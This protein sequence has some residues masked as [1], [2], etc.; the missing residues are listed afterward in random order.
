MDV[1]QMVEYIPSKIKLWVQTK[2][3][4][5]RRVYPKTAENS[6]QK[7]TADKLIVPTGGSSGMGEKLGNGCGALIELQSS[8]RVCHLTVLWGCFIWQS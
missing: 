8:H 1:A 6:L 5:K 3:T 2:R 4:A 7:K